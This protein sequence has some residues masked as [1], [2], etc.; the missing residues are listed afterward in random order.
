MR[1]RAARQV[2]FAFWKGM[3]RMGAAPLCCLLA[4]VCFGSDFYLSPKGD[5]GFPGTQKQ[6]WRSLEKVN[7]ATFQPGD[8]ILLQAG[9]T[10]AGTLRLQKED[11]GDSGRLV[12]VTS[13]GSGRATIDGGNARAMYVSKASHVAVRDL[14]LVGAGRLDGNTDSGLVVEGGS[15]ILIQDVAVSG[16][17]HSGLHIDGVTRARVNRVHAFENGFSGISAGGGVSRDLYIGYSMA[18]NNPGDPTVRKN[19]VLSSTTTPYG[20]PGGPLSSSASRPNM[21]IPFPTSPS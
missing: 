1:D 9:A 12:T 20:T 6:P 18:E 5:D 3:I 13:Y 21:R 14:R 10:F 16:F 11:S 2:P 8:R 17:Q 19:R 7:G 15:D 4:A